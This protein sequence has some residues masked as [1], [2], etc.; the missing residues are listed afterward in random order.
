MQPPDLAMTTGA[1]DQAG[2]GVEKLRLAEP[3]RDQSATAPAVAR[4]KAGEVA[5]DVAKQEKQLTTQHQR[6]AADDRE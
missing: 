4:V 2:E 3:P 1:G 5:M 6:T